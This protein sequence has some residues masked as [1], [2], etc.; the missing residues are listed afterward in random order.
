MGQST[1]QKLSLECFE[2]KFLHP[3]F[4]YRVVPILWGLHYDKLA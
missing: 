4:K 3:Q 1:L 2:H